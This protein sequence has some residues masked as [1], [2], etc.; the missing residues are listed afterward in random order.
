MSPID[1]HTQLLRA[2][3]HYVRN[4][5]LDEYNEPNLCVCGEEQHRALVAV[6]DAIKDVESICVTGIELSAS[7]WTSVES[8]I[9]THARAHLD[10]AWSFID[11]PFERMS[12]RVV[13]SDIE[14][15]KAKP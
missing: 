12:F 9:R 13:D 1:R 10:S 8:S 6:F 15:M 4:Y 14:L 2:A 11:K 7:E 5:L 3:K